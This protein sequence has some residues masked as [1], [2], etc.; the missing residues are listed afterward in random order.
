MVMVVHGHRGDV[1][2]SSEL[3]LKVPD[4]RFIPALD[5]RIVRLMSI[6][7]DNVALAGE[8]LEVHDLPSDAKLLDVRAI[9]GK[10][11]LAYLHDPDVTETQPRQ[12]LCLTQGVEC[13]IANV[14]DI[15]GAIPTNWR[16]PG[17]VRF[18][19]VDLEVES[20]HEDEEDDAESDEGSDSAEDGTEGDAAA[21]DAPE[22]PGAGTEGGD[23]AADPG[24]PAPDPAAT[25]G[26]DPAA[27]S[28]EPT[29]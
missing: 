2:V 8:A 5:L 28:G 10:P 11:H 22:S 9:E 14:D 18:F 13:D 24:T 15:E 20:G 1:C 21:T 25:A 6:Q 7:I 29:A 19:E 3:V 12:I 23:P 16:V 17:G 26:G 4:S 27:G